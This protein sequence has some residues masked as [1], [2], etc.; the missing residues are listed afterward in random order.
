MLECP[1]YIVEWISVLVGPHVGRRPEES[2]VRRPLDQL[3]CGKPAALSTRANRYGIKTGTLRAS[4]RAKGISPCGL[5]ANRELYSAA[6]IA[7]V[8][9][10]VS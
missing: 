3:C 6:Q 9:P 1:D 8:R 5:A 2:E 4:L 7:E 10:S